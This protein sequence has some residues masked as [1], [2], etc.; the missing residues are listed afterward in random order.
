MATTETDRLVVA[1]N[2]VARWWRLVSSP[3][4][5]FKHAGVLHGI[6]VGLAMLASI[7]LTTGVNIPH[8]IW[9]SVTV[10]VVIGGLQHLGNIRKKALER[11]VGTMIGALVG[12]LLLVQL[13][14]IGS[15]P[16]TYALMSVAAGICGYFAIDRPA[17]VA[18]LTAITMCI[19]AGHGDNTIDTGLW[20]TLNVLIGVAIALVFSFVLPLYATYSW[21]YLLARNLRECAHV[22]TRIAKGEPFHADEQVAAF[23]ALGERLVKARALMPSVTKELGVLAVR[24]EE[25]QRVHR[26]LLS[27]LEIMATGSLAHA[28]AQERAEFARCCRAE[29]REVRTGL[30]SMSRALRFGSYMRLFAPVCEWEPGQLPRVTRDDLRTGLQGPY[31]LS[32]R[33]E[34]QVEQMRVLLLELEPYWNIE[35]RSQIP[36]QI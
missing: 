36:R 3:Y 17:Y 10:L 32:Q 9:A 34:E 25:I 23:M 30:L 20:R 2:R 33:F 15:L 19:V 11:A 22:Y 8:G 28:D 1:R 12:L 24:L 4:Y 16:L 27:T 5:R 6:R 29:A 7:V 14:F 35:R 21:R 26:S 18:L 31:W 13:R